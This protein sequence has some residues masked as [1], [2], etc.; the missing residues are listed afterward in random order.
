MLNLERVSCSTCPA[1]ACAT[2]YSRDHVAKKTSGNTSGRGLRSTLLHA[3]QRQ[4]TAAPHCAA[5]M[6]EEDCSTQ[7]R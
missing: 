5:G 4:G 6:M 2:L 3:W 7:K 1:G